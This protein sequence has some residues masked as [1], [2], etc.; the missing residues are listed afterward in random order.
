[1]FRRGAH[2]VEDPDQEQGGETVVA[3]DLAEAGSLVEAV[4][5]LP[6]V[7]WVSSGGRTLSD[8]ARR[9]LDALRRELRMLRGFVGDDL[10]S[11]I[12]EV[13][14]T[15]LLD[16]EVAAKP[17]VSIHDARR[18]LD[19]FTEAVAGFVSTA[20]RVDLPTFLAWLEAADQE[21]D[22]LPVTQL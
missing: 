7:D 8:T 19:A 21:E 12:G 2:P 6:L 16:I 1:M 14:R 9:R 15:M 3:P 17:G 22:G 10:T 5:H 11:M 18:N 4:D 20:E 13:E